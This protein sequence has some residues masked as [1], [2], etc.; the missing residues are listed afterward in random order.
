MVIRRQGERGGE[1]AIGGKSSRLVLQHGQ[2]VNRNNFH[3]Q[4]L[5]QKLHSP[6]ILQRQ[7]GECEKSQEGLFKKLWK[8]GQGQPDTQVIWP[9][10]PL[11]L[12]AIVV[13][14][15]TARGL[16]MFLKL[17]SPGGQGLEDR[18]YLVGHASELVMVR[19]KYGF[20]NQIMKTILR[21]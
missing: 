4:P 18:S 21:V 8:Q 2:D 5:E 12:L 13:E 1:G 14:P 17:S 10:A 16:R 9:V 20:W 3:S 15:S 7:N 19:H 11:L 6:D